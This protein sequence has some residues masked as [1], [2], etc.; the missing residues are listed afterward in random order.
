M[1]AT[2][3]LV[4]AGGFLSFTTTVAAEPDPWPPK[5]IRIASGVGG[6]IHPAACVTRKGTV[7][8][9]Y[10]QKDM[11][12]LRLTRSADGGKTWATS[13][14]FPGTEKLDIYPGLS[15]L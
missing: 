14:A 3:R 8:V 4:L 13:V 11:K 1:N 2:I 15:R 5:P 10:S 12:D 7:R 6:H 9:V